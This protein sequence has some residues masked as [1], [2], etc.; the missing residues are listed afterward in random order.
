MRSTACLF[1]MCAALLQPTF[2]LRASAGKPQSPA[3]TPAPAAAAPAAGGSDQDARRPAG[4]REIQGDDQGT[5]AV[6]RSP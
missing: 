2:A 6:R 5:D 1:V 4:S 3:Q